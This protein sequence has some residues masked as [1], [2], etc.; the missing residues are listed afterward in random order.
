MSHLLFTSSFSIE[1]M[2][3]YGKGASFQEVHISVTRWQ[4]TSTITKTVLML[5]AAEYIPT[6]ISSNTFNKF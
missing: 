6:S 1:N 5:V 2:S 4:Q 3:L